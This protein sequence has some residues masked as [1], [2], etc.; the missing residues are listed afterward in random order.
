[1]TY[2]DKDSISKYECYYATAVKE[3]IFNKTTGVA[4]SGFNTELHDFS[5]F[6]KILNNGN[7]ILTPSKIMFKFTYDDDDIYF[8]YMDEKLFNKITTFIDCY[9]GEDKFT[10]LLDVH[11]NP[12]YITYKLDIHGYSSCDKIIQ[13]TFN[14]NKHYKDVEYNVEYFD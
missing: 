9:A 6:T 3:K 8:T 7:I 2:T 10:I 12:N 11:N 4:T 1:M 13:M 14:M 5:N